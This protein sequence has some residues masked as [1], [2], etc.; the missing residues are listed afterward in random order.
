MSAASDPD[1]IRRAL[2]AAVDAFV[3]AL[4]SDEAP[5]PANDN[6]RPAAVKP[7]PPPKPERRRPV[8]VLTPGGDVSETDKAA[9]AAA[10][11]RKGMV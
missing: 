3:D 10:L 8:R 4:E 6:A 5:E 9:A 1:A 7:P 11:R 2:H